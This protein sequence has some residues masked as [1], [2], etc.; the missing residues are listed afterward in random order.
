LKGLSAFDDLSRAVTFATSLAIQWRSERAA[1][2]RGGKRAKI[3]FKNRV[4]I[5]IMTLSESELQ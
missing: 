4:K 5:L 3:G 2:A 1:L